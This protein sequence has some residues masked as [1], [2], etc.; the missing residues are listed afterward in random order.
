LHDLQ[1]LHK[2]I[3][4]RMMGVLERYLDRGCFY[5]CLVSGECWGERGTVGTV[6]ALILAFETRS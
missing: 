6:A 4:Q 5:S 2:G 1:H 3:V